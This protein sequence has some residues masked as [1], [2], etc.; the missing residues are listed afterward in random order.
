MAS[1]TDPLPF[2]LIAGE[3][4]LDFVNTVSG[5]VSSG[6]GAGGHDWADRILGERLDDYGALVTWGEAAGAL[7]G[8]EAGRLRALAG[9]SVRRA[10]REAARARK[11]REGLYRIFKASIEGWTPGPE[12]VAAFNAEAARLRA[13]ERLVWNEGRLVRGWQGADDLARPLWRVV[14]S[15]EDLLT[16]DALARVGQCP[17]ERCGWL[18]LD[19]SR[20]ARRR[21]CTMADCGNLAKVRRFRRR[22]T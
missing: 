5:R 12:D 16:G 20:S 7:D 1:A 2:K 11:L 19:T 18:F 6:P 21:W 13:G 8:D 15:A 14:R 4:C 3:L 9:A 22:A 17:G 10:A